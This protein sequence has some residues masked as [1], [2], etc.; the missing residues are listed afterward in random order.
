MSLFLLSAGSPGNALHSALSDL[1]GAAR[2]DL[3]ALPEDAANR[4]HELRVGMKKFRA[5]L[6]LADP[7]LA[8][9][10]LAR[11]DE[12]AKGIKDAFGAE[13]DLAVSKDLLRQLVGHRQAEAAQWEPSAPP[14]DSAP[15][16][17][18]RASAKL[19]ALVAGL[20][21]SSLQPGE[22]LEA[23]VASYRAGRRAL[24]LCQT[25]RSDDFLFHEWRKRVKQLL[26][27]SAALGPPAEAITSAAQLLSTTLGTLHDLAVL[28]ESLPHEDE[29]IEMILAAKKRKTAREALRLGG[30]VFGDKPGE[31]RRLLLSHE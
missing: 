19:S 9:K 25:A 1:A 18:I 28:R 26:Y 14:A 17:A 27:Q 31:A 11:I 4:I 21:L 8:S 30:K 24:A 22:I 12:L 2:D 15:A 5:L 7:S 29:E 13:R 20:D 3:S 6:R 10:P 16:A 23:W